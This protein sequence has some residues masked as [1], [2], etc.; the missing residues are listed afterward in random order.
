LIATAIR[1]KAQELLVGSIWILIFLRGWTMQEQ[2]SKDKH[3]LSSHLALDVKLTTQQWEA[4]KEDQD[5]KV[6]LTCMD[7]QQTLQQH[8]QLL[9]L[10]LHRHSLRLDSTELESQ[11]K[12]DSFMLTQIQTN[13]L[14]F[15]FYIQ[16]NTT[17]TTLSL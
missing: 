15:S 1:A 16:T 5:Q 13:L 9:D 2:Q 10:T 11:Q 14:E 17:G 7:M 6:A 8:H 4:E 3:L 12:V